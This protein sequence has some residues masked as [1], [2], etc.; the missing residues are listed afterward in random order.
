MPPKRKSKVTK[1]AAATPLKAPPGESS[2]QLYAVFQ[3]ASRP[4][5]TCFS[6][7]QPQCGLA[8]RLSEG[9]ARVFQEQQ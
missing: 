3:L 5:L 6:L 8:P 9:I 2:H 1:A 7:A 4:M